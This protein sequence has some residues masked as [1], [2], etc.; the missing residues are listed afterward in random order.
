MSIKKHNFSFGLTWRDKKKED[1]KNIDDMILWFQEFKKR[2]YTDMPQNLDVQN[3]TITFDPQQSKKP[4]ITKQTYTVSVT[5]KK[6]L[7]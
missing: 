3:A 1:Q 7:K 2:D 5:V 6:S 4:I